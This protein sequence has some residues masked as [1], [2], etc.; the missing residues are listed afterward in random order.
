MK[1]RIRIR[2]QAINTDRAYCNGLI[3]K[4]TYTFPKKDHPHLEIFSDTDQAKAEEWDI[5]G[6]KQNGDSVLIVEFS[7]P[8]ESKKFELAGETY[9]IEFKEITEEE[10]N[11]PRAGRTL[12]PV[13]H[14]VLKTSA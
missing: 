8:G 13:Y 11:Y 4:L 14:F 9:Q 5:Y 12:E 7:K 10:V 2:H 1:T 6:A 3:F